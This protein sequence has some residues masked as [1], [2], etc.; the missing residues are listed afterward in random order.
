MEKGKLE[1]LWSER[2]NRQCTTAIQAWRLPQNDPPTPFGRTVS[3]VFLTA[4]HNTGLL[5]PLALSLPLPMPPSGKLD[6]VRLIKA[7]TA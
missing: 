7:G 2:D 6:D 5:N 4:L 1:H 3:E